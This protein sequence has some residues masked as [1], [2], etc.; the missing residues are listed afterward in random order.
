RT[1]LRHA[2]AAREEHEALCIVLS[3]AW[4]WMLRDLRS[5]ARQWSE[6]AA[7]LGPDPFAP[8]GVR[9]PALMEGATDRPPP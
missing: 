9:A 8:P 6:L 2:V 1:A 3:M 7:S 4:Y 5:D